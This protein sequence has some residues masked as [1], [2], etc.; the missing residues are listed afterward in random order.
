MIQGHKSIFFGCSKQSKANKLHNK[1]NQIVEE[2]ILVKF[3]DKKLDHKKS[4]MDDNFAYLQFLEELEKSKET[5]KCHSNE[6]IDDSN[7]TKA[8][9]EVPSASQN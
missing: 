1:E 8:S 5:N 9:N 6:P 4:K 2:L 7:D 3:D